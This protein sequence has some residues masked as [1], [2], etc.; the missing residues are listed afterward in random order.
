M[1]TTKKIETPGDTTWVESYILG[2]TILKM[3]VTLQVTT[4][5]L[6]PELMDKSEQCLDML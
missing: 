6:T 3:D 4:V 2:N 5:L 1:L